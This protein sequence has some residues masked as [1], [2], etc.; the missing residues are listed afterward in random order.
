MRI[1]FICYSKCTRTTLNKVSNNGD[2]R[3]LEISKENMHLIFYFLAS[4]NYH[5][6]AKSLLKNFLLVEKEI[7]VTQVTG[8]K[9][10]FLGPD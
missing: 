10:T 1:I 2:L 3:N 7:S 4:A 8:F 9:G 6:R 5:L